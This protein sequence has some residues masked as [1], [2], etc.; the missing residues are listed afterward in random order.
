MEVATTPGTVEFSQLPPG[1]YVAVLRADG[2][3]RAAKPF[4]KL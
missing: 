1:W 4:V 2:A 3:V